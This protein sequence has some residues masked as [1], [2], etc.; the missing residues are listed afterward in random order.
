MSQDMKHV[1]V[2]LLLLMCRD[3]CVAVRSVPVCARGHAGCQ[4]V[5]LAELFDRVIQHSARIHGLSSDLHS[6]FEQN[7]LTRRNQIGRA[8]RRCHTSHILT[9]AG[10]ENVQS[11]AREELT[12]VILKLLL[13][14]REPLSQFH[15]NVAHREDSSGLARAMSNMA[16]KLRGGVEKVAEKMQLLGMFSNS[17]GGPPSAGDPQP[18]SSTGETGPMSDYALLLCFRRDFD[19]VHSFLRILKCR[20]FPEHGC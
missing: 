13:A 4:P 1:S 18:P 17:L 16:H 11:L 6:E 19:K 3:L 15:R 12:G 14:W 20:M 2:L 8:N 7:L 10:K 9:P 5:S